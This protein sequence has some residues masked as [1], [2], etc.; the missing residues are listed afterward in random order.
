MVSIK[1]FIM[2][3][4]EKIV[5]KMNTDDFKAIAASRGIF[6]EDA[7]NFDTKE[8]ISIFIV[9]L[10]AAY[11]LPTAFGAVFDANTTNWDS[12]TASMFKLLPIIGCIVIVVGLVYLAKKD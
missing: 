9:V 6:Y 5:E 7:A 8:L 2:E 1:K 3:N 4:K 11:L 12:G 10:L